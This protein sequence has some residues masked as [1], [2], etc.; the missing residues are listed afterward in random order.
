VSTL[1]SAFII[2]S[3]LGIFVTDN[4]LNYG[5]EAFQMQVQTFFWSNQSDAET[6]VGW[7]NKKGQKG[8]Y[9]IKTTTGGC[10]LQTIGLQDTLEHWSQGPMFKSFKSS[11]PLSPY[12]HCL[13]Q[14]LQSTRHFQVPHHKV[15]LQTHPDITCVGNPP[16]NN[17]HFWLGETREKTALMGTPIC[18]DKSVAKNATF[19]PYF[20]KFE[21]EQSN[22]IK[23]VPTSRDAL[24]TDT[25]EEHLQSCLQVTTPKFA[26]PTEN[27]VNFL[28]WHACYLKI[29]FAPPVLGMPLQL[30]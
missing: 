26:S 29:P 14:S 12:D 11:T 2:H 1:D 19:R 15:L 16:D 27:Y 21:V 17:F 25:L 10:H 24:S 13:L 8:K 22:K 6:T 5:D 28:E 23:A 18:P 3:N 30:A 4:N 9:L 20:S 7:K